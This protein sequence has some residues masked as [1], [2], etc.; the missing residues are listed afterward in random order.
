M[1]RGSRERSSS[2]RPSGSCAR[3]AALSVPRGE[4]A[5]LLCK[6]RVTLSD[7][8]GKWLQRLVR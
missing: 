4:R 3:R 2:D 6:R 5:G 1:M 7:S 8:N